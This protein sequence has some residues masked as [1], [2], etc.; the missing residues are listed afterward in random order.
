MEEKEKYNMRVESK[1][2]GRQREKKETRLKK[3]K[4]KRGT[5]TANYGP[6]VVKGVVDV[7]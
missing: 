6:G 5:S 2:M 3:G 1:E 4:S 7:L